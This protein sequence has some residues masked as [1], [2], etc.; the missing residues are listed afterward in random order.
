MSLYFLIILVLVFLSCNELANNGLASKSNLFYYWILVFLLCVFSSLRWN[1]GT[2]FPEYIS[3]YNFVPVIMSGD[4][5]FQGYTNIEPGYKLLISISKILD[6]EVA[7]L[8]LSCF[9]SLAPMT[10]GIIKLN[11]IVRVGY[12]YP[13]LLYFLVFMISYNFNAMRQAISMGFFVLSLSYMYNKFTYKVFFISIVAF[14]FHSTGALIGISYLLW[15]LFDI[16]KRYSFFFLFIL[17]CVFVYFLNPLVYVLNSVGVNLDRWVDKWGGVEYLSI[18]M[19]LIILFTMFFPYNLINK[20]K[21]SSLLFNLYA[22]GFLVY[23]ALAPV[24]MMATRFNM[25]YRV[26]EIL[27]I[28]MIIYRM[29]YKFNKAY[30][31][32]VYFLI[33]FFIFYTTLTNEV[34][35]YKLRQF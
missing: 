30:I 34:N 20:D 6:T 24:G 9:F 19:R 18:L 26:L 12:F 8:F 3:I 17:L 27:I 29:S 5:V 16:S 22:H 21:I 25:F 2:D 35:L 13:L 33:S 11:K 15:R 28:P 23:L 1:T 14:T 10:L 4:N 31:M 7:F 32:V